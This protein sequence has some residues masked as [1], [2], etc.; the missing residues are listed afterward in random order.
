MHTSNKTTGRAILRA[1]SIL[2]LMVP[3]L[4][5]AQTYRTGQH[6]EPAYER[7]RPNPDGTFSFMFGYG[8]GGSQP[9][10]AIL[11]A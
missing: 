8:W 5:T 6:V 3:A 9:H 2:A 7:W 1:L 4:A 11:L 10:E